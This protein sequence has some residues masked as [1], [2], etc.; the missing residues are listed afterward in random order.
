MMITLLQAINH[1]G[2]IVATPTYLM[3]DKAIL[4]T[5]FNKPLFHCRRGSLIRGGL[6][7][8]NDSNPCC[9]ALVVL[10]MISQ[11]QLNM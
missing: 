7:S 10:A 3:L 8:S 2:E 4:I 5:Y 1:V 11:S 9:R 6:L